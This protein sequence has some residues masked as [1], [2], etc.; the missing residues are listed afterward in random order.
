MIESWYA[1]DP[2]LIV[3][4]PATPQDAYD[5]LIEASELDAPVLFLEHIGLYGLRGGMTGWGD[6]ID[7]VVD[8]DSVQLALD[9][10]RPHALGS[11]S[12][13]RG[14]RDIS[15]VTWGAMVHVG[16]HAAT[17]LAKEGIEVEIVDLRTCSPSMP[18]PAWPPCRERADWSSSMRG[19]GLEDWGI[20][21]RV[22]FWRRRSGCWGASSG[23]WCAGYTGSVLTPTRG[24]N[25]PIRGACLGG[26][27]HPCSL[28]NLP[29]SHRDWMT[30]R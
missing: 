22:E 21:Y 17:A 13:I 2:G 3:V 5:L 9:G 25:D 7:Q 6:R 23:H 1:N 30:C 20:R 18:Q 11:A 19:N 29:A 16:L 24:S 26:P 28:M 15:L 14:G 27:S 4:A 12:V 8:T 10:K